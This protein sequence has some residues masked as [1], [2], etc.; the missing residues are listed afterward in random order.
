M[1]INFFSSN[2]SEETRTIHTNSD[3]IE[4]MMSSGTYEINEELFLH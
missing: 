2:N 1:A 4:I 3:N